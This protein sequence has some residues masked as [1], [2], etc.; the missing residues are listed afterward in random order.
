MI[1]HDQKWADLIIPIWLQEIIFWIFFK[2]LVHLFKHLFITKMSSKFEKKCIIRKNY[3]KN[4]ANWD[5]ILRSF[6]RLIGR[7][8][9]LCETIISRIVQHET[10]SDQLSSVNWKFIVIL[11]IAKFEGLVLVVIKNIELRNTFLT[12]K[13]IS[14]L[15]PI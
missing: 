11:K 8:K 14:L 12:R 9:K 6:T 2:H 7:L 3:G 1:G 4:S 15:H 10:K 13:K 5:N